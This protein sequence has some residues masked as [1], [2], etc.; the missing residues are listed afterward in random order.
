MNISGGGRQLLMV[1]VWLLILRKVLLWLKPEAPLG[2]IP[3]AGRTLPEFVLAL[4]L[5]ELLAPPDVPA[6]PS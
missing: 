2:I 4:L 3:A 6:L 1:G 5:G